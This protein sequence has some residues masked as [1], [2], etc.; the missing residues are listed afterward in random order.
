MSAS[1]AGFSLTEVLMAACVLALAIFPMLTTLG[2]SGDS[3]RQTRPYHQAVFLSERALEM[4]RVGALEDPHYVDYLIQED[5]GAT[6]SP[7]TEGQHPFFLA[8]EDSREPWGQILPGSDRGITAEFQSLHGQTRDLRL[9]L[10]SSRDDVQMLGLCDVKFQWTDQRGRDMSYQIGTPLKIW[11][12]LIKVESSTTPGLDSRELAKAVDSSETRTLE[13]LAA[14]RSADPAILGAFAR[15][16]FYGGAGDG[17]LREASEQLDALTTQRDASPADFARTRRTAVIAGGRETLAV[18]YLGLI[19]EIR[20]ALETLAGDVPEGSLGNPAPPIEQRRLAVDL[21]GKLLQ[22]FLRNLDASMRESR[23]L[24]GLPDTLGAWR[25]ESYLAILRLSKM[26]SVTFPWPDRSPLETYVTNMQ[27]HF[28]GRMPNLEHYFKR[29]KEELENFE[30]SYSLMTT[31]QDVV[32]AR[33]KLLPAALELMLYG[34][35]PPPPR[36]GGTGGNDA[37]Q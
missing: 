24:A 30:Q 11:F 18:A 4:A 21:T 14:S 7:V 2:T 6:Q 5:V 3:L 8:I 9:S 32:T 17:S 25:L 36:P 27:E 10:A 15:L 1:R 28:R 13:E 35:P 31:A 37:G 26:A 19:Q 29:E 22:S 23:T 12:P 34:A 20:P 16:L 33:Q